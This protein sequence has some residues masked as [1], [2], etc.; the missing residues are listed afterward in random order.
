MLVVGATLGLLMLTV[1]VGASASRSKAGLDRSYGDGGVASVLPPNRPPGYPTQTRFAEGADGSA[2]ML[3]T[4]AE[5]GRDTCSS[6]GFIYR[7]TSSGAIDGNFGSGGWVQ[8]PAVPRGEV[9]PSVALNVDSN[10]RLLVGRVESGAVVVARFTPAGIPDGS[11]GVGGTMS[12]PCSGCERSGVWL[13]SAPNGRVVVERQAIPPTQGGSGS[14]LGGSVSLTRL[15]PGGW[16]ER[17]FGEAGTVTV[18]LGQRDYPGEAAVSPKG[19]I[20]FGAVECCGTP[21]PYLVRVSAE[22]RVDTKF[23]KAAGRSLARLSFKGDTSNL[24]ALLPRANGTIDLLGD[25][26]S[27]SGFDLRLKANGEPAKFGRDGLEALPFSV[28]A[29]RLGSEGTIFA[30]G[31]V[32]V[33]PYAAFRLLADGRVD[34]AFSP[35]GI[36][37]PL[38]GSGYSLGTPSRGKVL[39]FDAGL[40]ECRGGC[41]PTPGIARFVEGSGK[42]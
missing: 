29:A 7:V 12:L 35:K 34:R 36:R 3:N 9:E 18:Q 2:Y 20:L 11:F 39:V 42:G 5:C 37:L 21:R 13:L 14:N 31:N 30:V 27:G 10:G 15:T 19:A 40:H 28:A 32:G 16:P 23:G 26:A 24:R 41:P 1:A 38:S 4:Q 22:G 8:L 33:G 6:T 17:H 25:N